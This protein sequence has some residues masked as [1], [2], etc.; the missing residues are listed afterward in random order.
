MSGFHLRRHDPLRPP[1][2]PGLG[3]GFGFAVLVHALL[4]LALSAGVQWRTKTLPTFEAELWS[5]VPQAAAPKA[6]EPPPPPPEPEPEL[7]PTPKPPQPS[8]EELQQQRDAEIAIAK[9]KELKKKQDAELEAERK[10]QQLLK[11]QKDKA[12]RD[13]QDQL[14]R[15]K[16]EKQK[17][18]KEK[19]DKLD[20][21]NKDAEAKREAQRQENLRRIQGMA[22]A[23][24]DANASGTAL[25]SSGPSSSYGGRIVARVRP[26]IIYNDAGS[27]N[28][29][30]EIEVRAAPDGRIIGHKLIKS[31]GDLEWDKAVQRAIDKTEVLPRDVDG[32]V[33]SPIV[34]SFRLRD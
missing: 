30:A 19:Q 12:E 25:K 17:L 21:A 28:P 29:V 23:S 1:E 14:K 13:R 4:V 9:A 27:G 11:E 3:R 7:K 34:I 15:D 6:V 16:L 10:K 26:N 31:S 18:D 2:A 24:G 5:A 22:G 20:K 8:P 33:P 32:K